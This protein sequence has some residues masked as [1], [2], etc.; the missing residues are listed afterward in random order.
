M[1]FDP[2]EKTQRRDDNGQS[3]AAGTG[4]WQDRDHFAKTVEDE[5]QDLGHLE[6]IN[7]ERRPGDYKSRI[8]L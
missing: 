3:D 7:G 2:H 4:V 8:D 1:Q 5:F 6:Q